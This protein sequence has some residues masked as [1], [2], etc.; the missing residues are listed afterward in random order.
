MKTTVLANNR[1]E[2]RERLN[3]LKVMGKSIFSQDEIDYLSNGINFECVELKQEDEDDDEFLKLFSTWLHER[4]KQQGH[5]DYY[6]IVCHRK[7][8]RLTSEQF[9]YMERNVADCFDTSHGWLYEINHRM[10]F[11]LRIELICSYKKEFRRLTRKELS[12]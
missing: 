6:I 9:E 2:F 7:G 3:N 10:R 1:Q 5:V 8:E 12:R 11:R 4:P